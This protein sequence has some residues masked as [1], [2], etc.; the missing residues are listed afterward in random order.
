VH[1]VLLMA[2][3]RGGGRQGLEVEPGT[4]WSGA[5]VVRSRG[6]EVAKRRK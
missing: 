3:S 2:G 5:A 6:G 4:G 1:P